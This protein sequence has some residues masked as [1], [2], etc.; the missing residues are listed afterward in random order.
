M[1]TKF[2]KL[3]SLKIRVSIY[4]DFFQYLGSISEEVM[5]KTSLYIMTVILFSV[6]NSNSVLAQ[7][8]TGGGC[9]GEKN[10]AQHS[11]KIKNDISKND[12]DKL[13]ILA[14]SEGGSGGGGVFAP[15][16]NSESSNNGR[17]WK[18]K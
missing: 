14:S 1:L 6:I 9:N 4:I 11:Q 8:E 3:K 17:L 16:E 10:C 12:H 15:N 18:P 7:N 13:K 5:S 2:V